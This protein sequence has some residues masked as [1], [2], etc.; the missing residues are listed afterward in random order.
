LPSTP[1]LRLESRYAFRNV[2]SIE[3]FAASVDGVTGVVSTGVVEMVTS[4]AGEDT[5][6]P[7]PEATASE[8]VE[9]DIIHLG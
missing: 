2:S 8:V 6:S 4:G 9:S 7:A 1:R 5:A 3:G